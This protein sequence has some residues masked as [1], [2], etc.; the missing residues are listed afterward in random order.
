MLITIKLNNMKTLLEIIDTTN[1]P[2][3]I[4]QIIDKQI[5]NQSNNL[6]L[7]A[8]T[9]LISAQINT[10]SNYQNLNGTWQQVSSMNGTRVTCLIKCKVYGKMVNVDF[11]ISEVT[12]FRYNAQ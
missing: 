10:K 4:E 2:N 9:T 5:Q 12:G 7:K 8:M 1:E 11:H 3:I 6:K